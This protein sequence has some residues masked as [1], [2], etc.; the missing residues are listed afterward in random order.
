MDRADLRE[1]GY[2]TA[3]ANLRS[4]E[5]R[6][7]L[8]YR[9]A[10]R[11]DHVDLAMAEIQDRRAGKL[12]PDIRRTKPRELHEYA[13]L[14]VCPRN[15][16]LYVRSSRHEEICVLA[17][18]PA[19]LDL[20]GVVVTD[21]NAAS[22]YTRFAAAPEGLQLV[23]EAMTFAGYWTDAN[24]YTYYEKKRRKCAE[25]LVPDRIDSRFITGVYVSCERARDACH[26]IPVPWPVTI[27][28]NLF[29]Q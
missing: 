15:P 23:D 12:V 7:I 4:I 22:D 5:E 26:A 14:Y 3:I 29:F 24:V 1:L 17:V 20:E 27:D 19:V 28:R 11:I 16:M 25:V 2:I 8:C 10:Q 9:S 13:P 18:D 6:G 21:G